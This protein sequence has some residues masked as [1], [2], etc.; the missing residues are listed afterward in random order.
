MT[1]N[2]KPKT[3]ANQVPITSN[4]QLC[5]RVDGGQLVRLAIIFRGTGTRVSAEENLE[6]SRLIRVY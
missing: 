2:E 1:M 6:L 4:D 3:A 5:I